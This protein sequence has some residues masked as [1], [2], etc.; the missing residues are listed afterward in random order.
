MSVI[1]ESADVRFKACEYG[2]GEF[3]L[4]TLENGS[5]NNSIL[6]DRLSLSLQLKKGTTLQQAEVMAAYL[7]EHI[8][9]I[10][11]MSL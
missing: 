4:G 10:S 7:N 11:A 3:Y 9:K 6:H 8:T 5:P 2:D 1:N